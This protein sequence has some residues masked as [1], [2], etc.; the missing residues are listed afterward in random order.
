MAMHIAYHNAKPSFLRIFT[1][2][3]YTR[4]NFYSRAGQEKSKEKILKIFQNSVDKP[5]FIRYNSQAVKNDMRV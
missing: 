3:L 2:L 4:N 5:V 1:W